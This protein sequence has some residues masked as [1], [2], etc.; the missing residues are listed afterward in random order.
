MM[1]LDY[2]CTRKAVNCFSRMIDI[3]CNSWRTSE[4]LG[5]EIFFG[6]VYF[7]STCLFAARRTQP[8]K[9]LARFANGFRYKLARGYTDNLPVIYDG[10][11]E[12]LERNFGKTPC[13]SEETCYRFSARSLISQ[14]RTD[15]NTEQGE[16]NVENAFMAMSA[17]LQITLDRLLKGNEPE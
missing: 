3:E 8:R 6:Y 16:M 2:L 9:R 15:G 14:Y 7:A 13:V 17:R 1:F 12:D 5:I 4:M 11:V 10:L